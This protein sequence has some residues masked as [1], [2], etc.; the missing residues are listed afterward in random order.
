M[1]RIKMKQNI[2]PKHAIYDYVTTPRI[3]KLFS[4]TKTKAENWRY[5]KTP[6][7]EKVRGRM[8]ELLKNFT[9]L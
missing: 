2:E 3:A 8:D 1:E 4:V 9:E 7:P 6:I 5:G